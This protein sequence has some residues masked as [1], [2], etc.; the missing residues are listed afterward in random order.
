M[1]TND[2]IESPNP[3]TRRITV[4]AK[5]FLAAWQFT[6]TDDT[7]YYLGGV[8]I[9]P[10]PDGGALLVATNGHIL[11]AIHD[12]TAKIGDGES[13]I[14]FAPQS[15][16]TALNKRDAGHLHFVGNSAY[17]TTQDWTKRQ[18]A[19]GQS[20]DILTE[21]HIA[22]SWAPPIDATYPQWRAALPAT[23]TTPTGEIAINGDNIARITKAVKMVDDPKQPPILNW[24]IPA[25]PSHPVIVRTEINDR[26]FAV[27]MPIRGRDNNTA[28]PAWLPEPETA[29]P[30][31][32]PDAANDS[33]PDQPKTETAA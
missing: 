27:I 9:E 20:P 29:K 2:K 3:E 4:Q 21:H 17:V 32:Q 23:H 25:I 12:E 5:Y 31:A 14:C 13:W 30:K 24:F 11:C 22:V 15:I 26:L 6:S 7:R 28:Y 19:T 16:R 10:H 33:A 8:H 1:P 18:G